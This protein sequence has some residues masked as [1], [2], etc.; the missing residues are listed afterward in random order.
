M[1]P[2]IFENRESILHAKISDI[3]ED[4]EEFLLRSEII[5]W[6]WEDIDQ[7]TAIEKLIKY[8]NENYKYFTFFGSLLYD[9]ILIEL[10]QDPYNYD[11]DDI[12]WKVKNNEY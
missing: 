10:D 8:Y 7:N 9:F 6:H 12:D 3:F 5:D 4:I 1:N 11:V 2:S